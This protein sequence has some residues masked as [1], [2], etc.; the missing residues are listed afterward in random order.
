MRTAALNE[1]MKGHPKFSI[2]NLKVSWETSP[3][4]WNGTFAAVQVLWH[5]A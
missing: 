1:I 5:D 2:Q 3:D 4:S